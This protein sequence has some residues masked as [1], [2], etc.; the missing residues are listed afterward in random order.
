MAHPNSDD[1]VKKI[2]QCVSGCFNIG[3][4]ATGCSDDDFDCWC[5]EKNHQT[6]VDTMNEC[7]DNRERRLD[8]SCS[9]DDMFQMEN[10]YWKICEQYW[11]PYGTAAEP[12][13]A[14]ATVVS[15]TFASSLRPA[16]TT[17][18]VAELPQNTRRPSQTTD[19][20]VSLETST[21]STDSRRTA[22]GAEAG[23]GIGITL[24]IVLLGIAVVLWL[25]EKRKRHKVQME[26]EQAKGTN[27]ST[28]NFSVYE[29]GGFYEM[30]GDRPHVEEL[31]GDMK[32]LEMGAG[33]VARSLSTVDEV[34]LG[35]LAD[36]KEFE[37]STRASFGSSEP[38]LLER[39]SRRSIEEWPLKSQAPGESNDT[40]SSGEMDLSDGRDSSERDFSPD[41]E[42]SLKGAD[43][44]KRAS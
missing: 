25:A 10:S 15:T 43:S 19:T 27:S 28:D 31:Q 34:D 32:T 14:R 37:S 1:L 40:D 3:V 44:L 23:I 13:S 22:S 7:L 38:P 41:K 9:G 6:V 12:V 29:K 16:R 30:E 24:A 39:R 5:Y 4:A 26:L 8:R 18:S 36:E 11:E 35:T 42:E 17:A 21:E 20:E 33:S 2:P